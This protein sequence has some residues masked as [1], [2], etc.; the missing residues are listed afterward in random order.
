MT[1]SEGDL[2]AKT[3]QKVDEIQVSKTLEK[4]HPLHS[5]IWLKK[6]KKDYLS[7]RTPFIM[8]PATP[9]VVR[10]QIQMSLCQSSSKPDA[11]F[12]TLNFDM[13]WERHGAQW[14][15]TLEASNTGAF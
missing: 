8:Q 7:K 4:G 5:P 9:C 14:A 3:N 15:S 2:T 10:V 11:A 1:L 6:K 12:L 13:L